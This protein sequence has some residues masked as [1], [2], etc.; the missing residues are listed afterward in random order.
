MEF[1]TKKIGVLAGAVLSVASTGAET[2]KRVSP[3][4]KACQVGYLPAETKVA[5]LSAVP[6]GDVLVRRVKDDKPVLSVHPGPAHLDVDSGDTVQTVDFSELR[7]PGEYVLDA[8][9]LGRSFPFK[10][11]KDAFARPF[12]LAVRS[13]T[14]QRCGMAIS[15][16]PDFPQYHHDACHMGISP[17]HLSAGREGGR[18]ETG[19]WHDAGDFGKYVVNSGITTGTM[20]W[21]YEMYGSKLRKLNLDLPESGRK[22]PDFLAEVKWNLDWMLKM[23]DADGGV[24]HKATTAN[25]AGWIM[26][27]ADKADVLVIG[28]GKAPFKNTTA[29]ADLA[30]VA[31]IAARVYRPFDA[32]YADH[33]LAAARKAWSWAQANPNVP[34]GNNPKGIATGGYGDGDASDERLWAT[35]ELF[36]TT[37]EAQYADAFA[38]AA[39]KFSIK[40]DAA[41]GWPSVGNLGLYTYLLSGRKNADEALVSRIRTETLAAADAIAARTFANGYRNPLLSRD[42]IWGSNSVVANY[43]MMLRIADKVSPK[44]AYRNAAQDALHY[45]LGRNVFGKSFVTWVGSD[46]AMHP[47]HRPS[48]ADGIEQPWPGM[49]VGGPNAEGR[50]P[51]ARQWEDVEANFRVNEMAINWNA[52]LVFLLAGAL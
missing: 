22:L 4:I 47:H 37:G 36:R 2:P 30:A 15:L 33:C 7:S 11:G 27:E 26:P 39:S 52:P 21:T 6:S 40:A 12:R 32:A 24:W 3:A 28:T 1:R 44:S 38:G 9:G 19:G 20:L 34:F 5:V 10:I 35:A 25:F 49:L 8:P 16:A 50:T 41:Q 51:A 23:Q 43:G 48:G 42:Y 18:D 13:F 29:T 17:F 45:L 46:W 31:A 14:G